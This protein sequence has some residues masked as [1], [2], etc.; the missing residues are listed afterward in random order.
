M[1]CQARCAQGWVCE[2]HPDRPWPHEDCA[3]V[4]CPSMHCPWWRG[5]IPAALKTDDRID[6]MPDGRWLRNKPTVN[7]LTGT[8]RSR[9]WTW[10]RI[11]Q[12]RGT[13]ARGGGRESPP[14]RRTS[15]LPH[16]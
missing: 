1:I 7:L 15:R 4:P 11:S 5:P 12:R 16:R 8:R 9:G 10:G 14:T 13:E 6:V 3:G 2:A